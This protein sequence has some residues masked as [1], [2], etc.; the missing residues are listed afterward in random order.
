MAARIVGGDRG[1][2]DKECLAK[3]IRRVADA[4]AVAIVFSRHCVGQQGDAL[5]GGGLLRFRTGGRPG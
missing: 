5:A 2:P 4:M 1:G 3:R